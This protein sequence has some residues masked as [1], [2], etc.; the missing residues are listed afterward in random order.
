M[1]TD[2]FFVEVERWVTGALGLGHI[3]D[4]CVLVPFVIPDEQVEVLVNKSHP[5]Y[6]EAVP[7][8]IT[9]AHPE[10]IEPPCPYF[11]LC[12]GC[13]LQ[14]VSYKAQRK[15]KELIVKDNFLRNASIEIEPSWVN[16]TQDNI[17]GY[18]NNNRFT[19][20][21]NGVLGLTQRRSRKV[22]ETKK[23]LLVSEAVNNDVLPWIRALPVAHKITIREDSEGNI[24]VNPIVPKRHLN[25]FREDL[26][27]AI[28]H[29]PMPKCVAGLFINGK[30]YKGMDLLHFN[31][32]NRTLQASM[33]AFFQVN[34]EG[35]GY[36]LDA[37]RGF[38]KTEP[39]G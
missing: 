34:L 11:G 35:A 17:F 25:R 26:Q 31:V 27:E 24:F 39:G 4:K 1:R 2:I 38:L 6:L 10:R 37:A 16:K 8:T 33:N 14:H 7:Q 29:N 13:Q 36:L 22:V 3:E 23:C 12:G 18:R 9:R 19:Y 21:R 15:A 5:D 30:P 28:R 20:R 32:R